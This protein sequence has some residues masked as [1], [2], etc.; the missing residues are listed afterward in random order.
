MEDVFVDKFS[1]KSPMKEF[2]FYQGIWNTLDDPMLIINKNF[3]ISDLNNE[4]KRI[5]GLPQDYESNSTS[6]TDLEELGFFDSKLSDKLQSSLLWSKEERLGYHRWTF[7][8]GRRMN[9]WE[10][11]VR[12]INNAEEFLNPFFLLVGRDITE[13]VDVEEK[14]KQYHKFISNS[15]ELIALVDKE[16]KFTFFNQAFKSITQLTDD[17][18]NG[19]KFHKA[20]N[21]FMKGT[22]ILEKAKVCL[23]GTD[24]K[25]QEWFVSSSKRSYYL[26]F[27]FD[28]VFN[29]QGF[30]SG[31]AIS[32]RDMTKEWKAEQKYKDVLEASQDGFWEFD[33]ADKKLSL[34]PK[35][36]QMFGFKPEDFLDTKTKKNR[37]LEVLD[38]LLKGDRTKLEVDFSEFVKTKQEYFTGEYK[39]YCR[40]KRLKHVLVRGKVIERADNGFVKKVIGAITDISEI[41]KGQIAW[42]N[43]KES[44]EKANKAKSEFLANMS[45]EIR[46]PMNAIIGFTDI[47]EQMSLSEIQTKHLSSIK[48]CGKNLL[49]L[50]T[51]LLDFSKIDAGMT[52]LK[53][54][55]C[56]IREL[57]KEIEGV[58]SFRCKEKKIDFLLRMDNNLPFSLILDEAKLRQILINIIGNAIKFT[59]LGFVQCEVSFLEKRNKELIDLIITVKDTG[60]GIPKAQHS[61]IFEAFKQQKGQSTRKY[62]GTGLGLSISKKLVELMKGRIKI[63][64]VPKKGTA[65]IITFPNVMLSSD[66]NLHIDFSKSSKLSNQEQKEGEPLQ[67]LASEFSLSEEQFIGLNA[68]DFKECKR[69]MKNCCTPLWLTAR[70]TELSEDISKFCA[71]LQALGQKFDLKNMMEFSEKLQA[72]SDNFELETTQKYFYEF[73]SCVDF[74]TNS[75]LN[76]DN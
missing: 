33:L 1:D 21:G 42:R 27:K 52:E 23:K 76:H 63:E 66:R 48:V 59:D 65:F 20:L 69:L 41:K 25:F 37:T 70:E 28:P 44:A 22:K 17:D 55:A 29:P 31:I 14:L 49:S 74:F 36:Y 12:Y 38:F 40:K 71:S 30:V 35:F 26:D 53:Y 5:F 6:L 19:K 50:I 43:A 8:E 18:V 51:D 16:T 58:F 9:C 61:T 13:F 46:T 64:S 75:N 7:M 67:E 45:H 72:A 62:G 39:A 57:L 60:I 15:S 10:F 34:T 47:L 4:A 11:K 54:G 3:L 73:K 56:N 24:V 2:N 68:E 32:A